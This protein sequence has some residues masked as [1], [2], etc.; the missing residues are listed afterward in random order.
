MTGQTPRL[1]IPEVGLQRSERRVNAALVGMTVR[2]T[3]VSQEPIAHAFFFFGSRPRGKPQDFEP[4]P[5]RQQAASNGT[6]ARCGSL[7]TLEFA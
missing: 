2:A 3:S 1:E 5:E 4:R 7:I 6:E